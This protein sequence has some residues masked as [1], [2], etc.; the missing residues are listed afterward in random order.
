MRHDLDVVK[1]V[2]RKEVV[3][4][5]SKFK[6]SVL[7]TEKRRKVVHAASVIEPKNVDED[8]SGSEPTNDAAKEH[9]KAVQALLLNAES[10]IKMRHDPDIVKSAKKK[11]VVQTPSKFKA[12][13]SNTEKGRKVVHAALVSEPKNDAAEETPKAVQVKPQVL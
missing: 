13:V 6:A 2:K 1:S 11:Q 5:P 9:P 10:T 7:N 4:S 3:Q 8:A 12:S